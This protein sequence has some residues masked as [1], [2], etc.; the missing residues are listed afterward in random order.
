MKITKKQKLA[1]ESLINLTPQE[2]AVNLGI[3]LTSV[4]DHLRNRGYNNTQRRADK[5]YTE[6]D[7]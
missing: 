5:Y 3:P 7:A 4:E 2:I 1:I 6:S